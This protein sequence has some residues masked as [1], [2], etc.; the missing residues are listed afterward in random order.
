SGTT[1]DGSWLQYV[2][3]NG[4]VS[5]VRNIRGFE[6]NSD[7]D[8]LDR[9]SESRLPGGTTL[10]AGVGGGGPLI[11]RR[12]FF[13]DGFDA[14]TGKHFSTTPAIGSSVN[15]LTKTEY[16]NRGLAGATIEPDV[17]TRT[18]YTYDEQGQEVA[19]QLRFNG[20]VQTCTATFRDNR[21]R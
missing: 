2:D 12:V 16:N 8:S 1:P 18:E 4:N 7:F 17:S 9:M 6:S 3:A 20:A 15:R 11:H 21:D 10:G 13:H 19:K 14:V 5:R